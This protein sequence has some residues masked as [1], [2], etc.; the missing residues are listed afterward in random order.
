MV[1]VVEDPR[2]PIDEVLIWESKLFFYKRGQS[3]IVRELNRHYISITFA[4]SVEDETILDDVCSCLPLKDVTRLTLDDIAYCR[5]TRPAWT[6]LLKTMSNVEVLE[7]D[8]ERTG[9]NEILALLRARSDTS[10]PQEQPHLL[11]KLKH[12]FLRHVFFKDDDS[13]PADFSFVNGLREVIIERTKTARKIEKVDI[14]RCTDMDDRD[15]ALLGQTVAVTW[16]RLVQLEGIP[17][18]FLE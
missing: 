15:V 13:D 4:E 3:R 2:Q 1:P 5:E 18:Y 8:S 10:E 17:P 16:D 14:E 7:I 11:P 6:R 9:Q 12:L